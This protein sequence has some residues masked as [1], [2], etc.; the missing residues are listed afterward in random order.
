[1]KLL[2]IW[3]IAGQESLRLEIEL[4]SLVESSEPAHILKL[5]PLENQS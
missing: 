5:D 4:K 2:E 3:S 1:M